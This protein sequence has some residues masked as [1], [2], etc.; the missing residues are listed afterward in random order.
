MRRLLVP[1]L[2][3]TLV[4]AASAHAAT[5]G[6][7]R[8]ATPAHAPA[9]HLIT[10]SHEAVPFVADDYAGALAAAHAKQL[11]IFVEMWAPW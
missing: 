3:A 4:S 7:T 8:A 11:P 2:A 1:G 5:P 10:H 9:A 6:A